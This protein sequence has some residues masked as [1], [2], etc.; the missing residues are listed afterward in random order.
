MKPKQNFDIREYNSHLHNGDTGVLY[1]NFGIDL[2][3]SIENESKSVGK[4][5]E[6]LLIERDIEPILDTCRVI[7][8]YHSM[9]GDYKKPTN[10][11]FHGSITTQVLDE[12]IKQNSESHSKLDKEQLIRYYGTSEISKGVSKVTNSMMQDIYNSIDDANLKLI[13]V[14]EKYVDKTIEFLREAYTEENNNEGT[15]KSTRIA[16][17]DASIIVYAYK[18]QQEIERSGSGKK[19]AILSSDFKDVISG[20]HYLNSIG[21]QS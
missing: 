9:Q 6:E 1:I 16:P 2:M 11:N 5:L 21:R 10:V 18:I 12:I 14:P 4:T 19:I 13:D 20:V 8:V 7:D 17:A 3:N 15:K